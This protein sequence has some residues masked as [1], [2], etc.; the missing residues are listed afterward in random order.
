ME[1]RLASWSSG[2]TR[3][4][5]LYKGVIMAGNLK[6]CEGY[7]NGRELSKPVLDNWISFYYSRMLNR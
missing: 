2:A 3:R 1:E 6:K 7:E 5:K 4:F